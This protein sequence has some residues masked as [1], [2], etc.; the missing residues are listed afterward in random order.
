MGVIGNR[1]KFEIVFNPAS[2]DHQFGF[3]EQILFVAIIKATK[4][5]NFCRGNVVSLFFGN[6]TYTNIRFR[7]SQEN[8]EFVAFVFFERTAQFL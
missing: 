1:L 3:A 8:A 2:V 4:N 5:A 6:T 7:A